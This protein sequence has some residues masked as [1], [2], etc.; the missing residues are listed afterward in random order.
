MLRVAVIAMGQGAH[1]LDPRTTNG[2]KF[3][4]VPCVAFRAAASFLLPHIAVLNFS[5]YPYFCGY[6]LH[7]NRKI[8]PTPGSQRAFVS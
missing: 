4:G 7:T 6:P 5:P 2:S 3:F 1:W 8:Y